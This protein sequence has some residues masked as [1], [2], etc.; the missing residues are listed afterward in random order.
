M[1]IG[2]TG[3]I[4]SGKTTVCRVFNTLGI[5]VFDSDKEAQIIINEDPT[6]RVNLNSI[7]GVDLFSFGTLDRKLLANLI[8]NDGGMLLRVNELIHPLVF[9]RFDAWA[10]EQNSLY[11]ILESAILFESG[12]WQN[13]DKTISVI[14]PVKERIKRVSARSNMPE[15]EILDRIKNQ[16]DDNERVKKSDFVIRNG[17]DDFIIPA[18]LQI[19]DQI[20]NQI[21]LKD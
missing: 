16:M 5:P 13:V 7:A 20:I 9:E 12:A 17:E 4:G 10:S 21:R 6:V 18:V 19:H 1:K 11:S 2:I 3:G 14:A 15:R 8:F